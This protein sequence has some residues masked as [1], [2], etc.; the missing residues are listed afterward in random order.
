MGT[1]VAQIDSYATE[2]KAPPTWL[3]ARPHKGLHTVHGGTG[4]ALIDPE[5]DVASCSQQIEVLA[6]SG[7]SCGT[8]SFFIAN[9]ACSAGGLTVGYDGTVI[10]QLPH[11]ME[12]YPDPNWGAH[13]CTWRYWP[14]FFR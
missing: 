1:A 11:A 12:S 5:G 10:Q 14:G 13:T 8:A 2:T 6:P 7:K 4:Y 3:A 9:G